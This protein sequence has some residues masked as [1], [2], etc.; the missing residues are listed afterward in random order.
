M[1]SIG[2]YLGS[3][4]VAAFMVWHLVWCL[5]RGRF[6]LKQWAHEN[7][8]QVLRS[9]VRLLDA[10]PFRWSSSK[11]QFSYFVQVRDRAGSERSGWVRCGS[12]WRGLKSDKTE[13][14]WKD[15]YDNNVA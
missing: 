14:R 10:G 15:T 12:F 7:G 6:L 13:V 4:G 1:N 11:R 3:I 2:F 5:S 9:Q 8:Y